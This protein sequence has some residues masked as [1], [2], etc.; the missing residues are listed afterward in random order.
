MRSVAVVDPLASGRKRWRILTAVVL[1][2]GVGALLLGFA[3]V[4][5]LM[6]GF[7]VI[8]A[9]VPLMMVISIR[10]I[11]WAEDEFKRLVRHPT[12][13]DAT[14]GALGVAHAGEPWVFP[15]EGRFSR[16]FQARPSRVLL[17][18]DEEAFVVLDGAPV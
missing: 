13:S 10:Q 14:G 3:G 11:Q 6:V 18:F 12:W 8:G 15:G 1:A 16:R 4:I 17:A 9:C 7:V 2:S 5:P